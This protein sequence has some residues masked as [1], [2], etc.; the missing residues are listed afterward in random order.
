MEALVGTL[1]EVY[2]YTKALPS[3]DPPGQGRVWTV[4]AIRS[5]AKVGAFRVA[6]RK[7]GTVSSFWN[8]NSQNWLVGCTHS[9]TEE[10]WAEFY[11]LLGCLQ[12][13][14]FNEGSFTR[15][16]WERL[17]MSIGLT[18]NFLTVDG[19]WEAA[20]KL[21]E[22]SGGGITGSMALM[23]VPATIWSIPQ[24]LSDFWVTDVIKA[25][26]GVGRWLQ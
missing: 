7:T 15:Q 19:M 24:V 11:T 17:D 22:L 23:V 1:R 14:R 9:S 12:A 10:E 8:G 18:V 26:S 5:I 3:D 20:K 21:R 6:D 4:H 2:K 16:I 25:V 13:M